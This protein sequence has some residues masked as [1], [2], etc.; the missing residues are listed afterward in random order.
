MT[1]PSLRNLYIQCEEGVD[2]T[3][4]FYTSHLD[5]LAEHWKELLPSA[6]TGAGIGLFIKY[7]PLPST[8]FFLVKAGIYSRF[9]NDGILNA[10]SVLLKK[11]T[12]FQSSKDTFLSPFLTLGS[13]A[14]TLMGGLA[15][16][17][18]LC[19][20]GVNAMGVAL[21]SFFGSILSTAS[22]DLYFRRK[23]DLTI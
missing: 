20:L 23:M 13:G 15:V 8:A 4:Y 16:N 12:F 3:A 19:C 18:L 22:L 11:K 14:I 1:I 5:D 17:V 7:A 9:I 2:N 10:E 21:G 6:V